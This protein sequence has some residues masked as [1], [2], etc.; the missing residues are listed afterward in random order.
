MEQFPSP[1]NNLAAPSY[2]PLLGRVSALAALFVLELVALSIWLDN[3]ALA[4]SRGLAGSVHDW[5]AWSVRAVVGFAG[6]FVTCAF[7]KNRP[8][9]ESIS[10]SL[11]GERVRRDL[12][13]L[14]FVAIALFGVLSNFLYKGAAGNALAIA[15]LAVGLGAIA[16]GVAAF[17]PSATWVRLIRG[18][19][20]LW[21]GVFVAVACACVGGNAIRSLWAPAARLTLAL[22]HFLLRFSLPGLVADPAK[23]SIGTARFSVEIA[24][25]CSGLEG[26]GLMLAFTG[27]WLAL[28]RKECRFPNAL[29]LLPV[30]VV[31][32]FLLNAV[33]I[34]ALVAIG[35]AGAER[36]ALGGFHSQ[37][38]WIAFNVVALGFAVSAR[39]V[40]WLVIAKGHDERKMAVPRQ[41]GTAAYLM[42]FILILA[43]GMAST[44]ASSGFEWMYGLRLFA[45][46]GAIWFYRRHYAGLGWRCTWFGPAAGLAVFVLWIALDRSGHAGADAMPT[47]LA[48]ASSGWR[49]LWIAVR[50]AAAIATVP[51]A[52]EL[53]FRGYLL[54][55]FIAADFESISLQKFNWLA[56][57]AS[58]VLFGLLHGNRWFAG[59]LAG[60]VYGVAILR[61][62]KIGDAVAAHATTNALLAGYVLLFG[63]WH[64]W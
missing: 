14:H 6:L 5:G 50:A 49:D 17:V 38:G 42:P 64:Y 39:H 60:A 48:A 25:E 44:A 22:V 35:N 47:A 1:L 59:T 45:A 28:F 21:L 36:I 34:A 51:L 27:I 3:A 57:V 24:N 2:A 30:G 32:M 29:V 37:A 23:M 7:M 15:W 26:I 12:L 52:E 4:G 10:T 41:N 11:A 63:K 19:G 13:G 53:A 8:L 46:V 33:R 56:L 40:P 54:R 62:G 58:S 43:A 9:L 18:T 16:L 20:Q 55:R 31:I 61:R